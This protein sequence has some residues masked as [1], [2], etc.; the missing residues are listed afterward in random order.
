MLSSSTLSSTLSQTL[1]KNSPLLAAGSDKVPDK[2]L[3]KDSNL[4]L[5][6][7]DLLRVGLANGPFEFAARQ[8]KK[9]VVDQP[10]FARAEGRGAVAAAAHIHSRPVRHAQLAHESIRNSSRH[11]A[12]FPAR[13]LV[14]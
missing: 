4:T 7:C 9:Q 2:V 5:G 14:V 13:N 8:Q 11:R 6:H 10:R 1:S 3:D 12:S